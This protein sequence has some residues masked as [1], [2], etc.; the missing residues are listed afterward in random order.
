MAETLDR[1]RLRL[2]A[3]AVGA[4][5]LVSALL[6][7]DSLAAGVV[8][9]A[10]AAVEEVYLLVMGLGVAAAALGALVLVGSRASVRVRELPAVEQ[11]APAPTAGAPFDDR[12][13]R[14]RNSL[15]IVGESTRTA[16]RS[17]LQT[18][19]IR[20]LVGERGHR[21]PAARA[22]VET[23][24]WTDDRV[25]SRFLADEAD[26][27]LASTWGRAVRSAEPP[28]AYRARRTIAAIAALYE[29]TE[30]SG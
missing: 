5:V 13:G 4:V 20:V 2:V 23:G 15:P 6:S 29:D 21:E 18:A 28:L 12:V 7:A 26:S 10:R 9:T 25:A 17:R 30:D 1:A 16:V 19:A 3:G 14:W 8:G 27:V 24:T 11:P 22:A